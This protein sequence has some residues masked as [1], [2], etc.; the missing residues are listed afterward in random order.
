MGFSQT[1]EFIIGA[2]GN[3]F[4][5]AD[6][7]LILSACSLYY[8]VLLD[9]NPNYV[10]SLIVYEKELLNSLGEYTLHQENSGIWSSNGR[11]NHSDPSNPPT[12]RFL[13]KWLLKKDCDNRECQ[14]ELT[15]FYRDSLAYRLP[16]FE[17]IIQEFPDS[18]KY[19]QSG[20]DIK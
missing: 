2:H 1:G 14:M 7:S 9:D 4:F 11:I 15:I 17:K 13:R 18:P 16:E 10:D 20:Q 3:T 8:D 12:D 19:L 6:S 5:N